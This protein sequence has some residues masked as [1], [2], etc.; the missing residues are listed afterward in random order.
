MKV[1]IFTP[2]LP[3]P[4]D[5]GGKIRSFYLMR[6]LSERFD[7]HLFAPYYAPEPSPKYQEAVR[8]YC[9]LTLLPLRKR[10]TWQTRLQRML[11]PSP[12]VVEHFHTPDAVRHAVSYITE[13]QFD[14]LIADEICMTPYVEHLHTYPRIVIRHKVERTHYR[15]VAAQY[16]WGP[17]KLAL[18][19]D[20]YKAARYERAKMPLYDGF[21]ACSQDDAAAILAAG[22]CPT[23]RI[24]PNGADLSRYVPKEPPDHPPILLYVG[25]MHYYPNIDAVRYFFDHIY[26]QVYRAHPEIRVQIVGHQPPPEIWKLHDPPRVEIT[27]SVPDVIPYYDRATIFFVPLRLGGGT[28]LKI[29]EAMAMGLPVVSTRVGAEGLDVQ[30]GEDILFA[31]DPSEFAQAILRL[32]EQ[33]VLRKRLGEKGREVARRYDWMTLMQPFADFVEEIVHTFRRP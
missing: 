14:V 26:H 9:A 8:Q 31:D 27:G 30:D 15:E 22:G 12:R 33:P 23:Y 25:T 19:L 1:A 5:T 6:A 4:P 29:I 18:Y 20:A 13:G 17:E 11:S 10:W 28:R 2:Y 16:P 3:Y 24:V 21:L 32:L 7:V